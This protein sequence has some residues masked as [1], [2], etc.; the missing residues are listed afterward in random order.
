MQHEQQRRKFFTR[1]QWL[2][3]ALLQADYG[4]RWSVVASPVYITA[5]AEASHQLFVGLFVR[6]Q[7]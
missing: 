2:Y 4:S 5:A 1:S 3:R 7:L 6:N